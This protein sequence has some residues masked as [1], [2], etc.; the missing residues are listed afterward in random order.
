MHSLAMA[1][2]DGTVSAAG[3]SCG[4]SPAEVSR[5]VDRHPDAWVLVRFRS[6]SADW[7]RVYRASD[8]PREGSEEWFAIRDV[9]A[10]AES[11]VPQKGEVAR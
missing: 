2:A 3:A 4:L 1:V 10:L 7:R 11:H 8:F 6:D 9:L 5:L